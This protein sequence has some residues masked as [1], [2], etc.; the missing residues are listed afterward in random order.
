MHAK[1]HCSMA[2]SPVDLASALEAAT[3]AAKAAGAIIKANFFKPKNVQHKGAVDLV[4]ETDQQCEHLIKVCPDSETAPCREQG[5]HPFTWHNVTVN[6][7][8]GA[9]GCLP[10]S[11][12]DAALSLRTLSLMM[13]GVCVGNKLPYGT[14]GSS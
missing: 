4:T 13:K 1:P 12:D 2:H 5:F 9:V 14:K 6:S 3:T 7:M 10:D 8:G 11:P